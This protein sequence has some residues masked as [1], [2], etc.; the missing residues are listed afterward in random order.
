MSK[1][2]Q[3]RRVLQTKFEKKELV[4][5]I[6]EAFVGMK[7]ELD[8]E[9]RA[10]KKIWAKREQQMNRI[11]KNTAGLYGDLQGIIGGALLPIPKLQLP[12]GEAY[13]EK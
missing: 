10:M 2:V 13:P 12:P 3:A 4:E 8:A 11:V 7:T 9:K 6:V 5:A 1:A